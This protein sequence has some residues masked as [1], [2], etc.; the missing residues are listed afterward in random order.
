MSV[1]GTWN[2]TISTP[3]GEQSVVLELVETDGGF[4]GTG[5]S[6]AETVALADLAVDGDHLTATQAVTTPFPLTVTLDLTVDGDAVT[7]TATAGP[8]PP[9]PVKG[10][11]A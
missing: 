11:R 9:A 2:L 10:V 1:A 3:M 4:R 7:G 6:G 5:A 8:F